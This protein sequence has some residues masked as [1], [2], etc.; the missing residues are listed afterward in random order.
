MTSFS[1]MRSLVAV[2]LLLAGVTAVSSLG[3]QQALDRS[4]IPA[5]GKP[6][7][8]HVPTMVAAVLSMMISLTVPEGSVVKVKSVEVPVLLEASLDLTR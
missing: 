1:K 8:L 6:P 3:A 5:P 4:K 7:V 2:V